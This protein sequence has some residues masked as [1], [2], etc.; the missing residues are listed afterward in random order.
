[1]DQLPVFLNLRGWPCLVVGAGPIGAGKAEVLAAAGGR[2]RI[3]APE[4]RASAGELARAGLVE[5]RRGRFEESDLDG[6]RLVVAA[7]DDRGLNRRI[8]E[9]AEAR[10]ILA[11]SASDARRGHFSMP[12]IVDRSPVLAAVSTGGASPSLA[13]YVRARL[14]TLIPQSFGRLAELARA[15]RPEVNARLPRISDRRAFWDRVFEGPIAEMAFAGRMEDA[16]AALAV[17]LESEG[18]SRPPAGEVYLVGAG[19]GD[20]DLLTFRAMRLMQQAD[21][22][23]HDRLVSPGVLSL[24][25][26]DAEKI[27]AGKRRDEHAIRQP[28]INRL[29]VRLAREGRRVLRLK[30]GDPFIFGRGGE[31]IATLAEERIPFQVVPGVTAASGCA[32]YAGIPL[33]HRDYAH[34]CT[35][36]TGNLK[37]GRVALDWPAVA[38]PGQ[39]IVVYMGLVGLPEI[40]AGLVE[41]GLDAATPA[42]LVEQGTTERQRVI[43]G[44]LVTLAGHVAEAHVEAPTLVIVGQVVRLR[45]QLDW[46]RPDTTDAGSEPRRAHATLAHPVPESALPPHRDGNTMTPHAARLAKL[47]AEDFYDDR[48]DFSARG[49]ADGPLWSRMPEVECAG[50]LRGLGASD[51]TVRLYLTFVS[52]MDRARDATRLWRAGARLFERHPWV[53][54]PVAASSKPR[55]ALSA[56]LSKSGV[57]Q[58]HG[59]DV[60]AWCRIAGRLAAGSGPVCRVIDRGVGDA[61]E[62][63]QELCSDDRTGRPRFPMLRGPKLGPMWVRI[64]ASPGGAAV[65]GMDTIDVAVDVQVRRVTENLGVT[66]T[67][68]LALKEARPMIQSAWRDAVARTR[69]D[70]PSGIAGTCAALDPALWSFGKY[71]CSHCKKKGRPV[72]FGRACN[73]CRL[74]VSSLP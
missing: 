41:H 5:L 13:R 19:P 21:V 52:A 16:R 49:G 18:D 9:L 20:P 44:T 58:R 31:E 26:R 28:A 2:V 48:L 68:G 66:D 74:R 64:M 6:H 60:D 50:R 55:E 45:D 8:V 70:G 43:E 71:G 11:N 17:A 69:F 53:F 61:R 65:R 56:V 34:A 57:T 37:N 10:G 3:V 42:A 25:R 29:L 32:A 15:A 47:I 1:M 39:T 23:V 35:F 22:V 24:V 14:E 38:R 62:L 40:C 51:R 33:T 73:H 12:A 7:T 36:V 4:I 46:F 30:G 72:P 27:Y 59:Q 63:L 67:V 54:D